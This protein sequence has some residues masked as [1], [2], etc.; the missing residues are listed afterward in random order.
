MRS[1]FKSNNESGHGVAEMIG[2]M[3]IV[4]VLTIGSIGLYQIARNAVHTNSIITEVRLRLLAL[5]RHGAAKNKATSLQTLR[6][7][8]KKPNKSLIMDKYELELE[9]SEANNPILII[10]DLPP[11]ICSRLKARAKISCDSQYRARF[12]LSFL[13]SNPE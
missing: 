13:N 5:S 3:V 4:V 12:D 9:Q 6:G 10:H 1:S 2:F 7:L 8:Q 11:E